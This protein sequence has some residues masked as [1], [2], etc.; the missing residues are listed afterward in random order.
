MTTQDIVKIAYLESG[1]KDQRELAKLTGIGESSLS[2]KL[3][4]PEKLSGA[5][6]EAI[7][8]IT[9]M[10]QETAFRFIRSMRKRK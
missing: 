9:N 2:R 10:S 8:S 6:I 1:I 7:V 5:E 4:A 3:R